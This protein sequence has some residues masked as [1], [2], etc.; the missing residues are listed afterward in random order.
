MGDVE[1][2][3]KLRDDINELEKKSAGLAAELSTL[4]KQGEEI[5]A[6]YG[7]ADVEV[8]KKSFESLKLDLKTALDA[9]ET[10]V[11][12]AKALFG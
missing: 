9:W 1:R 5:L 3:V 4:H 11:T 8:L 7:A 2:Y 12:N 6:K 10:K